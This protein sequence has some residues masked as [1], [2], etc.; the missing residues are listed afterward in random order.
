[1]ENMFWY[2]VA[3]TNGREDKAVELLKQAIT[4]NKLD[5]DFGEMLVPKQNETKLVRGKKQTV[6]TRVFPGYILLQ[7][8]LNPRSQSIVQAVKFISHFVGTGSKPSIISQAEVD[9][10]RGRLE[11]SLVS[12]EIN[13]GL[14]ENMVVKILD[15]PFKDFTGKVDKVVGTKVSVLVEVFGRPTPVELSVQAVVKVV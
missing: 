8:K 2:M 10:M 5:A 9:K 6:E 13:H 14:E 15:G 7:M 1:M 3:A 11:K 4:K 12:P